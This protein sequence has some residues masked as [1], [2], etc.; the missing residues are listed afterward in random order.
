MNSLNIFLTILIILFSVIICLTIHELGH[1]VFAKIFKMNVKEFSIG[2]GPKIWHTFSKKNYMR[3]SIRLLPLGAYV[4]IDSEE[5][6][7]AYLESPNSKKYNFYL[8][9]K[10]YNLI[11][12]N[13]AFYW[14]KIIVMLGGIFFNLLGFVFFWGIWSL[15]NLGSSLM[16]LDFLKNF[17]INIG[18]SFVFYNLWNSN[19]IPPIP[20]TQTIINGDFLLRYLISI[21]LG[22]SI[23]NVITISPLDGWK[24]FQTSFEKIFNKKLSRKIQES[25]SLIG[26]I[27]ILWITIGNIA[28]AIA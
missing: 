16:L 15:I 6:R 21:N 7:E 3:F 14:Q 24:I 4:L 2:F 8:R 26:V 5:L 27:I 9:P 17:F 25:L 13:E 18:K 20:G 12:F 28:N 23:L 11:L 22:T 10:L 1:F 19:I